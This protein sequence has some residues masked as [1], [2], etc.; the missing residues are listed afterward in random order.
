MKKAVSTQ[1]SD[2][3]L[4]QWKK[5]WKSSPSANYTNSPEWFLA[6]IEHFG[7]SDYKIVTV[8][9]NDTLIAICALV[10]EIHYGIPFYTIAPRDFVCG[11]PF[12]F[13]LKEEKALIMLCRELTKIGN[14]LFTNIPEPVL[15]LLQ[16]K[17]PSLDVTEDSVNYYLPLKQ[18]KKGIVTFPFRNR[19][20]KRTRG[21][22]ERFK[23]QRYDGT[24]ATILETV[25]TI[26][27]KSR[28]KGR[29][30]NVFATKNMRDFY[31]ILAKK[32]QKNMRI[33]ILTYDNQPAAYEIGF[34]SKKIYQ[35]SQLT[36]SQDFTEY[37][38]GKVLIVKLLDVLSQEG[39]E[40]LDFGSG[41][42]MV[43]HD[44]TPQRHVLYTVIASQNPLIRQYIRFLSQSRVKT[45]HLLQKNV[46]AY[47]LYR[48]VLKKAS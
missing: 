7:Y 43:K 29:G 20:L 39:F 37:Y 12:L 45:Y 46:R 9:K 2:E 22:E 31:R 5:L 16:K 35:G 27:E 23:I 47:T 30:Y 40:I 19:F 24:D 33:H 11:M 48:R 15:T 28:K 25:F 3:L 14:I 36:F 17:L 6:V 38:P 21:I 42:S 26:D 4:G 8:H 32:L 10:K 44:I 13:D 34:V 1:L 18:F 41:D